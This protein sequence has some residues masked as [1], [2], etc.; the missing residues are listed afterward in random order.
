VDAQASPDLSAGRPEPSAPAAEIPD[1]IWIPRVASGLG[2]IV[3]GTL[4]S[5]LTS[6]VQYSIM[7][8]VAVPFVTV[9]VAAYFM[10][11]ATALWGVVGL[12]SCRATPA[13][14]VAVGLLHFL[15]IAALLS[16]G[17][18]VADLI[19]LTGD[20]ATIPTWLFNANLLLWVPASLAFGRYL[21]R[22][23][24]FIDNVELT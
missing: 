13:R 19:F 22:L 6:V 1:S 5:L 17:L 23:A 18:H 7:S 15:L 4:L 9:R 21:I 11:L 2:T 10:Y 14:I 24:R 16:L 20:L 12:F 8:Q 3:L